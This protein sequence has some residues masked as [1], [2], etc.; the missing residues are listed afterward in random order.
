MANQINS[1]TIFKSKESTVM[2]TDSESAISVGAT[3]FGVTAHH[4][5]LPMKIILITDIGG[6]STVAVNPIDAS[7]SY[8][9]AQVRLVFNDLLF[10]D[11]K[12]NKGRVFTVES[13]AK[14]YALNK[15]QYDEDTL[16]SKLDDLRKQ[17]AKLQN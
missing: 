11:G 8:A 14:V 13:D 15:L 4:V 10:F 5:V 2:I 12:I 6:Y 3:I 1:H 7:D 16:M 9:E 17:K